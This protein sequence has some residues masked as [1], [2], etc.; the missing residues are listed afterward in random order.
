M[1]PVQA[2]LTH[3]R[4]RHPGFDR[5]QTPDPA[6][7][8]FLSE[9]AQRLA[10]RTLEINPEVLGSD[11]EIPLPLADFA[12][13][14]ELP[15]Y[16]YLHGGT[17]HHV[18]GSHEPLVLLPWDARETRLGATTHAG[19]LFLTG[20]PE[21]WGGASRIVLRIAPATAEGLRRLTDTVELPVGAFPACVAAVA[22]F[23]GGRPVRD[24]TPPPNRADLVGE[25]VAAESVYLTEIGNRRRA[26]TWSILE[27]W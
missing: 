12:A 16:H 10:A 19:R 22:A 23:M 14:A 7:V 2:V 9:Y 18:D 13:G 6:A 25:Q 27:V 20:R 17:V 15:D 11:V 4:D 8:R 24:G 21:H 26:Q 3:A 5:M 1:F